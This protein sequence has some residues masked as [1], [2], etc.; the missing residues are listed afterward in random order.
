MHCRPA[1]Q[2]RPACFPRDC[3]CPTGKIDGNRAVDAFFLNGRDGGGTGARA[4]RT[5]EANATFPYH[6][7]NRA[8]P[9]TGKVYV[10]AIGEN[11][12]GFDYWSQMGEIWM[13][14]I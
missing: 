13:V 8:V 10:D 11:S 2:N 6:Q 1:H 3:Q 12:I 5:G 14:V 4:A 7:I 9:Y